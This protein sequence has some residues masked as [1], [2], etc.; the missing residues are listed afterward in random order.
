MSQNMLEANRRL[1]KDQSIRLREMITG[2]LTAAFQSIYP[3]DGRMPFAVEGVVRGPAGSAFEHP[4]MLFQ[5]AQDSGIFFALDE[6]AY[7][8]VVKSFAALQWQGKLF[9]N[10]RPWS[11]LAPCVT[12]NNLR[13]TI[14]TVGL[15]PSQIILELTEHDP[16]PNTASLLRILGLL[17]DEGMTVALDDVG[18]GFASMRVICELQPHLIKVDR[19]FITGI[20]GNLAKPRV[21]HKFVNLASDIGAKIIA[22]GVEQGEDAWTAMQLGVDFGQG[23]LFGKAT[24]KPNFVPLAKGSWT[25][26]NKLHRPTIVAG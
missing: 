16:I 25:P 1:S 7:L 22:E 6:A 12:L 11:L 3:A 10:L 18:A 14:A 5:A 9:L 20:A 2:G 4:D 21:V 17:F 24:E 19:F 15:H 23:H 8:V 13:R 26:C